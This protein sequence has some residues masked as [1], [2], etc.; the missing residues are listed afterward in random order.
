M[1]GWMDGWMDSNGN[2]AER[3]IDEGKAVVRKQGLPIRP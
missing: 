2:D 1:D 3:G